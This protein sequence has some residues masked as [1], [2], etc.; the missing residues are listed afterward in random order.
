MF[1]FSSFKIKKMFNPNYTQNSFNPNHYQN[2]N[3]LPASYNYVP[4]TPIHNVAYVYSTT[5]SHNTAY[6]HSKTNLN[7]S[8]LKAKDQ[9]KSQI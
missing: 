1:Y 3:N 8:N 2:Y 6:I 9:K 4:K 5:P 7:M